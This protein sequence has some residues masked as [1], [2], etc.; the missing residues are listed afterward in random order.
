MPCERQEGPI[1][2][3][4]RSSARSDICRLCELSNT[5]L[6]EYMDQL[7]TSPGN[8]FDEELFDAIQS[9]LDERAPIDDSV[10]SHESFLKFE[11][12]NADILNSGRDMKFTELP[13]NGKKRFTI[14]RFYQAVAAVLVVCSVLLVGAVA[15]VNSPISVVQDMGEILVRTF[16]WG[17][18]GVLTISDQMAEYAS[19]EEALNSIG[20][21]NAQK[22]T[23]IPEEYHLESIDVRTGEQ[24]EFELWAFYR[25]EEGTI[26]FNISRREMNNEVYFTEKNEE[27]TLRENSNY[28]LTVVENNGWIDIQ[29]FDGEYNYSLTGTE[30]VSTME[31]I[32]QSAN[33]R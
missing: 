29:W 3:H 11:E 7:I 2:R 20:A 22:I 23:W 9:L 15:S 1:E 24:L 17:S 12:R 18:S 27:S 6:L 10:D 5:E 25:S 13:S 30:G 8:G 26:I 31:K 19:L 4:L 14:R 16:T 28:S 21:T 32:V 33:L